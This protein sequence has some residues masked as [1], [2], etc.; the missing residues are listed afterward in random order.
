MYNYNYEKNYLITTLFDKIIEQQPTI[1]TDIEMLIYISEIGV[2][3]IVEEVVEG[4]QK[5][6]LDYL[7]EQ[8]SDIFNQEEV[9]DLETKRRSAN[10]AY[11]KFVK[12]YFKHSTSFA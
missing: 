1:I 6:I 8:I 10:L 9:I 7:K 5:D 12:E 2:D 4:M 3:S 11:K